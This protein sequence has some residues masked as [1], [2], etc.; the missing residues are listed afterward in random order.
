ME[1]DVAARLRAVE[2][3]IETA[4]RRSGRKRDEVKLMAVTKF[5]PP[6]AVEAVCKAGIKL[7]GENRVQEAIGKHLNPLKRQGIELHL[8]GSLQRNKAARAAA[9]FDCIQSVDR[10]SLVEE[11]GSLTAQRK[12]SLISRLKV[13][14]EY[15]TGEESKSGFRDLES[16][17]KAAERIHF[18]PG[19]FPLGLMTMAPF[20]SDEAAI[21][22]SFRKLAAARGEIQKRFGSKN[23]VWSCL[24]MGMTNDF[25]IAIEEGSNLVR[26]GTAIFGETRA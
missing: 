18:F 3:K 25:E 2:E 19:L 17:L 24:S 21:R 26:I 11:L 7:L 8:I 23:G 15:H 22:Q 10:D 13:M 4:C 16:L 5:R 1:F 14:L 6:D 9:F 12:D 20:T